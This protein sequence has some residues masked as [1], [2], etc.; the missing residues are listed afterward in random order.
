MA[1]G[2]ACD[3]PIPL[4]PGVPL[5][6]NFDHLLPTRSLSKSCGAEDLSASHRAMFVS[7]ELEED[8]AHALVVTSE[9]DVDV[10]IAEITVCAS[11]TTCAKV[12]NELGEGGAEGLLLPAGEAREAVFVVVSPA[13]T[14]AFTVQLFLPEHAPPAEDVSE[15]G[16]DAVGAPPPDVGAQPGT[17][18]PAIHVPGNDA[19]WSMADAAGDADGGGGGGGDCGVSSR[20]RSPA[21]PA[22]LALLATAALVRRRRQPA[23]NP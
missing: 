14:G 13:K 16:G 11:K 17:D 19:I 3:A 18:L 4:V 9:P 5:M 20:N 7:V 23:G 15:P 8:R 6:D 22:V 21:W 1:P 2:D 10:T 12:A